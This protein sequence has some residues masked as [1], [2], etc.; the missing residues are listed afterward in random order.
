LAAEKISTSTVPNS[1]L[2]GKL[3]VPPD[4]IDI[5]G[6]GQIQGLLQRVAW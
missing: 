5:D 6:F 2:P 3:R 1:R 4:M